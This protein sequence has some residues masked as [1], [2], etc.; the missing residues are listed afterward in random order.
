METKELFLIGDLLFSE[1][2]FII[3]KEI[4]NH[5]N[6]AGKQKCT[7]GLNKIIGNAEVEVVVSDVGGEIIKWGD[8]AK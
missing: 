1:D 3:E 8:K 6:K 7:G 4:N 2:K 5:D